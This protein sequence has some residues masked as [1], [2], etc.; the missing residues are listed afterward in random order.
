MIAKLF[1]HSIH[2][3]IN[4]HRKGKFNVKLTNRHTHIVTESIVTL[5]T[6][7]R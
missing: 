1:T 5:E 6:A 2:I 4:D 7:A 3:T